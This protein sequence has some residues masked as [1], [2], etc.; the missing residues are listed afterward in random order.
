MESKEDL[1]SAAKL[2]QSR[3]QEY[4]P[5]I[6]ADPEFQ[7]RGG[8]VYPYS[9]IDANLDPLMSLAEQAGLSELLLSAQGASVIDIGCAN[10]DLAFV[11]ASRGSDVVAVDYSYKHDQ[12]PY[13]VSRL[14]DRLGLPLTVLD[15]SV[16][17]PF[18]FD[19]MRHARV[20][21]SRDVLRRDLRCFDL[22]I[23]VGLLYH[24]K[25]PFAFLESLAAITQYCVLGTHLFTHLPSDGPDIR[26]WPLAYLVGA[27]ELNNDPTNYWIFDDVAITR[28]IERCGF[29]IVSRSQV[30]NNP[31][32]RGL[33]DNT[34]I[35]V[36]G[37]YFLKSDR[38]PSQTAS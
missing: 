25:N 20:H 11:F 23:C 12:A 28:L 37:F 9:T 17:Q 4:L 35:G 33:P 30:S 34:Q 21:N 5:S 14:S 19:T 7:R 10:G 27:G 22:A 32:G 38:T 8:I 6:C 26:A 3:I 24:L 15:M 31:D 16:D 1:Y 13:I 2:I 18:T 36:R 29:T